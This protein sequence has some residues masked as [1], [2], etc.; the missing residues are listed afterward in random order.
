MTQPTHLD[1]DD[2]QVA[3]DEFN[4]FLNE[5]L[6]DEKNLTVR[7]YRCSVY[8]KWTKI[9]QGISDIIDRLRK[10]EATA[11]EAAE[12]ALDCATKYSSIVQAIT[13]PENQPSQYGTVPLAMLRKAEAV[14]EGWKLVPIEPTKE[15]WDAVNK[16]DDEMAAGS[17]D[18]KGCSIEQA[19]NCLLDAAPDSTPTD[20]ADSATERKS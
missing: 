7:E 20:S 5:P 4:E 14:R 2:L 16:L 9:D 12:K 10:A 15:M 6:G 19:W 1:P 17:Y 18:G 8:Q 13:D 3:A 11:N